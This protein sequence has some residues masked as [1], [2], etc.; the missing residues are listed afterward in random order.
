MS[1][2]ARIAEL[3]D[4]AVRAPE[5]TLIGAT[6]KELEVLEERLGRRVPDD[7]RAL[8]TVCNGGAIGP[9]GIYGQRPERTELDL[10]SVAASYP[11]WARHGWLPVAGDGCGNHWVLLPDGRIG[12]IDTMTNVDGLEAVDDPDLLSFMERIL[13]ADQAPPGND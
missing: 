5:E 12:F 2:L 4:G 3:I 13:T 7:L 11:Q 10:P 6:G 8:L 1:T 9:G